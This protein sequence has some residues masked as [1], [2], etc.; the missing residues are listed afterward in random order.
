MC[1]ELFPSSPAAVGAPHMVSLATLHTRGA[2]RVTWTPPTNLCGLNNPKYTI[3]YGRTTSTP[4]THPSMASSSPFNITGLEV[5][6][7]YFVRLAVHTQNGSGNFSSW[8]SVTT[9][10]GERA[11]PLCDLIAWGYFYFLSVFDSFV[12]MYNT[13][14]TVKAVR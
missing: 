7:E 12:T 10:E 4:T 8:E 11:V 14:C 3:Q 2:V 1:S 9:Y 6:Q 5:G 13:V